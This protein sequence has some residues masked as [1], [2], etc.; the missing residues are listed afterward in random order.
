MVAGGKKTKKAAT[1][2][3]APKTYPV[4]YV[5]VPASSQYGAGRQLGHDRL[6]RRLRRPLE[7]LTRGTAHSFG[8]ARPASPP[9]ACRITQEV[10]MSES[11]RIE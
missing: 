10:G 6:D 4:G 3:A 7:R 2:K 9:A 8:G 5:N 1:H 11:T